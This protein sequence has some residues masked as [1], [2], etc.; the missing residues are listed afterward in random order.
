MKSRS[1][2]VGQVEERLRLWRMVEGM[3][4]DGPG[5]TEK[6]IEIHNQALD[7]ILHA[8]NGKIGEHGTP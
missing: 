6:E 3:R 2:A 5:R 7:D 8:L 4:W 1:Y